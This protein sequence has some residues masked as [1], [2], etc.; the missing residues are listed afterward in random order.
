MNSLMANIEQIEEEYYKRS[1]DYVPNIKQDAFHIAGLTAQE[2]LITGGNRSGKSHA[3]FKEG[4]AHVTGIYNDDW[5]GYRFEKPIRCWIAGK[6][7]SLI[8]E[9]IQKDLLGDREQ[10]LRGMIHPSLI[11]EKRRSGSSD[12]YRTIYVR[13]V[14]GGA[15]KITF[16]TYEEGREAFQAGKIDLAIM[17][18]E[19]PFNI[20]Q[21]C[22][23]R[24]MATSKT[25]RGMIMVCST[26][27]K[28]YSEFFNYF[29]DDRHPE[30]V[31]DSRW[32]AHITWEDAIHLP[33]E[34]KKRLLSGMSPH[35]IEARTKGIPWPGSGL[36]YPVPESMI[37]CEP[38]EIPDYWPR[39]YA[40]DFGWNH[41]AFLFAAPDRDNDVIYF[42]AENSVPERTPDG[43][44]SAL[45]SFGINWIP[46]V[47]DPAGKG[48]QQGDGKKPLNL[49]R[50]AGFKN[51]YPANNSKEEGILR[52][53]QRF[54]AGQA[55]IFTTCVKF[56]AEI[57][58][59][60]R[61]EDG[62]P[63]KKDDH[64]CDGARYIAMSG[65]QIAVSKNFISQQYR[66]MYANSTPGYF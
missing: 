5:K 56:R 66:G 25:A 21:E 13:H 51:L 44:A 30:E 1:L 62:I 10:N 35:E 11:K 50:E 48:S 26:P 24:T 58:K 41:P 37:I 61:D 47:Y 14:S 64:L 6:T 7:S 60:A 46:A 32:H 29:M 42:Y 3:G 54:Q 38:F 27:L 23:M 59:Y 33:L 18:E 34:E 19:P 45:Q 22:K 16:K 36:V 28:G 52:L 55:K 4:T 43:H 2:R 15:S 49:Y 40:I 9:T 17:D 31:K 12:M 8:A 57:R 39:V 53:L 20:Y 65:L 63:N